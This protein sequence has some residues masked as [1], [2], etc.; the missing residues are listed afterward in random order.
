MIPLDSPPTVGRPRNPETDRVVINAVLDLIGDGATLS[1]LSLV[2]IARRAGVSRNSLYRRWQTKEELYLDAVQTIDR[3]LPDMTQQSARENLVGLLRVSFEGI[4]DRGVRSMGRAIRAEAQNYPDLYER[5]LGEIVAPFRSAMKSAIRQGK[6][7]GE[8][9]VDVD[10]TLLSELLIAPL[11][12]RM[13]S[14]DTGEVDT[15]LTSQL[16][17][18]LLF[19]GVAPH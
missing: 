2:T 4:E 16:I 10:E 12:S 19:E 18:D 14:I 9:R 8:I 7:T 17:T 13:T 5:Y 11:F 6:E 1:S 3:A 15:E